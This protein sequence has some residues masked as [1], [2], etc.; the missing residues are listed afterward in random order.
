[1]PIYLFVT[2]LSVLFAT[3]AV[4]SPELQLEPAV[5][6][7]ETGETVA[8]TG[9]TLICAGEDWALVPRLVEVGPESEPY[10]IGRTNRVVTAVSGAAFI[11]GLVLSASAQLKY[12]AEAPTLSELEQWRYRHDLE[13]YAMTGNLL[14]AG[15][16]AGIL[17]GITLP[18]GPPRRTT[19]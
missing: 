3:S 4:A 11:T 14:M 18:M 8:W 16:G 10:R 9:R 5:Q 2:L 13:P 6:Q 7:L 12:R 1:M 19:R 15:G 17:L